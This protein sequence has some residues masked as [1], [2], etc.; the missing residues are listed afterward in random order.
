M[1]LMTILQEMFKVFIA[2]MSRKIT[3]LELQRHLQGVEELN[4]S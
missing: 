3:D 2:K 1:T 4:F